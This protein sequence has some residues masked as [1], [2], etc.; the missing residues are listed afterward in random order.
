MADSLS[1]TLEELQQVER[2][3]PPEA[4]AERALVQDRSLHDEAAGDP[5]AW[6]AKQ[7]E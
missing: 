5:A 2:F 6:W 7:A 3:D 4:F 1:A